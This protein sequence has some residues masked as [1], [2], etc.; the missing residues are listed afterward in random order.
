MSEHS[1]AV[2]SEKLCEFLQSVEA[3]YRNRLLVSWE[4]DPE[5][6]LDNV[7]QLE[8]IIDLRRKICADS[9]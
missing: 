7:I 4:R 9:P 6:F 2:S 3:R 5:G 1:R 8:E